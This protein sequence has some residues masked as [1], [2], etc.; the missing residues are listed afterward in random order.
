MKIIEVQDKNRWDNFLKNR[1]F[2]ESLQSGPW[3]DF[4][5]YW[6]EKTVR[7]G[8]EDEDGQLVA[9]AGL[10]LKSTPLGKNYFYCPRGPVI[11]RN[12]AEKER[13]V[14]K[15]IERIEELARQEKAMF[16]RVEPNFFLPPNLKWPVYSTAEIQPS[17]TS[18][19]DLGQSEEE[20]MK[21]M[22]H[23]TRYNTRLAFKKGVEVRDGEEKDLD[24]FWE[25][26]TQTG[27]RDGFR[28]H[29]RVYY[30]KMLNLDKEFLKMKVA[31]LEGE[32]V[33][34]GLFSFFG[35]TATYMHGA[36]SYR[37]RRVMAPYAL[38]WRAIREAKS[39]ECRY[40]DLYGVDPDKWPGVTRFKKG[41]G[42]TEVHYPGT[43]DVVFK[44]GW[45]NIYKGLRYI[46][47]KI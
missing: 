39:R 13:C 1:R 32:V 36:S 44:R 31:E 34:V 41:F 28:L 5:A 16:V 46:R 42:G 11:N 14:E 30:E 40:Y 10:I 23:K 15:L 12:L 29:P 8:V 20:L 47:R 45:Y 3:L 38:Q 33:A 25:L 26:M 7:L 27:N 24:K 22:H 6:A 21:Q 37:H 17:K 4:Q 19:L 35:A 18:I 2:P 43:R 9:V